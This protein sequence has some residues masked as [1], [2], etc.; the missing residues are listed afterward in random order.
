MWE[1]IDPKCIYVSML[2]GIPSTGG[3]RIIIIEVTPYVV[4]KWRSG[5]CTTFMH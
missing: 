2:G 5:L 1:H 4:A 3:A